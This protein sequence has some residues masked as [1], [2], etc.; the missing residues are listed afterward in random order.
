MRFRTA[1]LFS[2]C[3]CVSDDF[4]CSCLHTCSSFKLSSPSSDWTRLEI[5]N[6]I[7]QKRE[8]RK[9]EKDVFVV[10]DIV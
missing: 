5:S 9:L 6:S 8:N 4:S 3:V 7:L 2:A 1:L 10:D